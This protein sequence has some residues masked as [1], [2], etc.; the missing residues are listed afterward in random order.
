MMPN[1]YD[2]QYF[3]IVAETKN[4]SRASERLGVV[5]PTLSQAIKRLEG[6]I[7][8][9]LFIRNSSGLTLTR[10]GEEFLVRSKVLLEDWE[11]LTKSLSDLNDIPSG[12][13]VLG[14][15]PSVALYSLKYFMPKLGEFS[16]LEISIVHGLSREIL[17]M[18]VSR[19]VDVG[20]VINPLR[21]NDLVLKKLCTD[22]VGFWIGA[23]G[24]KNVLIHDPNLSQ[25]QVLLRKNHPFDKS[26]SS[27]SLEVIGELVESGCGVGILPE[28]VARRFKGL[29][30]FLDH[31][32]TD[33]LYLVYRADQTR[34]A[35]FKTII[36]AISKA[37]I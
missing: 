23:G 14:L 8:K 5:Q 30:P 22:K 26:I 10:V 21:H 28:R 6:I 17:E 4:L 37:K 12:K 25:T 15:H 13:Y 16:E 19:K 31:W 24:D 20:L 29:K 11:R 27:S 7:G 35:G 2:I 32:F 34:T 1:P 33:E 18:V 3:Q 9:P 36:E